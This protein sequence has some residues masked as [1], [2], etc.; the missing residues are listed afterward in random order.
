MDLDQKL[1]KLQGNESSLEFTKKVAPILLPF[2]ASNSI[3]KLHQ[4]IK[5]ILK[6]NNSILRMRFALYRFLRCTYLSR[7]HF[8]ERSDLLDLIVQRFFVLFYRKDRK[9][10]ETRMRYASRE[11]VMRNKDK[12][13]EFIELQSAKC[14]EMDGSKL[15]NCLDDRIYHILYHSIDFRK[16]LLKSERE[17]MICTVSKDYIKDV[18]H[19]TGTLIF[20]PS[21]DLATEIGDIGW[22]L[23]FRGI[24]TLTF[25]ME[26]AMAYNNRNAVELALYN[27]CIPVCQQSTIMML[28]SIDNA[29]AGLNS[30]QSDR[31]MYLLC[32]KI[33]FS[34][35]VLTLREVQRASDADI[36][37]SVRLKSRKFAISMILSEFFYHSFIKLQRLQLFTLSF[38]I[39]KTVQQITGKSEIVTAKIFGF[40][41]KSMLFKERS[42]WKTAKYWFTQNLKLR[43]M[44]R[45]FAI[46]Q[47]AMI[48]PNVGIHP[49]IKRDMKSTNTTISDCSVH[50]EGYFRYFYGNRFVIWKDI[51]SDVIDLH[52]KEY[53]LS[54]RNGYGI[55]E[56]EKYRAKNWNGNFVYVYKGD[57]TNKIKD[58]ANGI[59]CIRDDTVSPIYEAEKRNLR[60]TGLLLA[61]HKDPTE[62]AGNYYGDIKSNNLV[63]T[64]LGGHFEGDKFHLTVFGSNYGEDSF[65]SIGMSGRGHT[66]GITAIPL[67]SGSIGA[68]KMSEFPMNRTDVHHGVSASHVS[69]LSKTFR[70]VL[71]GRTVK[72]QNVEEAIEHDKHCPRNPLDSR[73]CKCV[74]SDLPPRH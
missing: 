30:L 51:P 68:F 32:Y 37:I 49:K 18:G 55:T 72:R 73:V 52:A 19:K 10:N 40:H 74:R 21:Q 8:N 7:E 13:W 9:K 64:D 1:R 12:M 4:M 62:F 11:Y 34:R 6:G 70:L 44:Q 5:D 27:R 26:A 39:W 57:N 17:V 65:L 45:Q 14:I 48:V 42:G 71:I 54:V 3:Y 50:R 43:W 53:V 66:A 25:K 20:A 46:F 2:T 33:H 36:F 24:E 31:I 22:N 58:T 38:E 16:Y 47:C 28:S 59:R 60:E 61:Q 56:Y 23:K 15:M 41:V 35:E 29:I 67:L 63:C 69:W